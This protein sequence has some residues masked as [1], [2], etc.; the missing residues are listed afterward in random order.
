MTCYRKATACAA[1]MRKGYSMASQYSPF[2]CQ[3]ELTLQPQRNS[4]YARQR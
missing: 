1:T 2:A 4:L 3:R